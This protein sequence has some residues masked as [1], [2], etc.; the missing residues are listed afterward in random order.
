MVKDNRTMVCCGDC[1]L[2]ARVVVDHTLCLWRLPLTAIL[3]AKY[4]WH[5]FNLQPKFA[6]TIYIIDMILFWEFLEVMLIQ[7]WLKTIRDGNNNIYECVMPILSSHLAEIDTLAMPVASASL[8]DKETVENSFT[9]G[10]LAA[11]LPLF[12]YNSRALSLQSLGDNCRS[13]ITMAEEQSCRLQSIHT[14][15]CH[16]KFNFISIM[17]AADNEP[18]H[19]QA[20]TIQMNAI[21][22]WNKPTFPPQ[23]D[24]VSQW[25][26]TGFTLLVDATPVRLLEQS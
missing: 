6:N 10:A 26:T 11:G 15:G 9:T 25:N 20:L 1:F 12:S 14:A 8:D 19:T 16:Q 7:H 5:C 22:T 23:W 18:P 3:F 21:L 13:T 4:S 2:W 17:A 24:N